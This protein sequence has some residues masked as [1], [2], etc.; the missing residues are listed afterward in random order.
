MASPSAKYVIPARRD[1]GDTPP[2]LPPR[3]NTRPK[4]PQAGS[5]KELRKKLAGYDRKLRRF[6]AHVALAIA[7]ATARVFYRMR[8]WLK[9]QRAKLGKATAPDSKAQVKAPLPTV[10]VMSEQSD[11]ARNGQLWHQRALNRYD[12]DLG[13]AAK[14]TRCVCSRG[15]GCKG[16]PPSASTCSY[17]RYAKARHEFRT[18][19]ESARL[20]YRVPMYKGTWEE[21]LRVSKTRVP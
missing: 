9:K 12:N 1:P 18:N 19:M 17:W 3:P 16:S 5:N 7:R 11:Y 13:L 21:Y 2:P 15:S 14:F 10:T 20:R 6:A 4:Y 8:K